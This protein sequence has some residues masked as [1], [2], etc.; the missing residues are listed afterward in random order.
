MFLPFFSHV[1]KFSRSRTGKRVAAES[2][3]QCDICAGGYTPINTVLIGCAIVID[4]HSRPSLA[5]SLSRRALLKK[6]ECV[7]AARADDLMQTAFPFSSSL[8]RHLLRVL[9]FLFLSL[10]P[11]ICI[12]ERSTYRRSRS[13]IGV[14]FCRKTL[15][16]T[17]MEFPRTI[18][19]TSDSHIRG[20]PFTEVSRNSFAGLYFPLLSLLASACACA[21]ILSL[22][23]VTRKSD[24]SRRFPRRIY[25]SQLADLTKV[26]SK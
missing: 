1:H 15:K 4:T 18:E 20:A 19:C 9:P 17:I 12:R 13:T 3:V 23:I 25:G 24:F 6:T 16:Y 7:C 22:L 8:G 14:P 5:F 10:S 26:Q 11:R 21:R 2:T